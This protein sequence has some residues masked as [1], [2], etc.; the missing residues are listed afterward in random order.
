MAMGSFRKRLLLVASLV[1][2]LFVWPFYWALLEA[3]EGVAEDGIRQRLAA[4]VQVVL[5]SADRGDGHYYQPR[6]LP[7]ERFAQLE[8]LVL[9]QVYG[10]SGQLLWQTPKATALGLSY[11]PDYHPEEALFLRRGDYFLYDQDLVHGAAKVS[12]VTWKSSAE[13]DR[14]LRAF[15]RQLKLWLLSSLCALIALLWLGLHWGLQPLAVLR[16]QLTELQQGQRDT[17]DDRVP[18]E[19]R[20]LTQGL[21]QMLSAERQQRERYR[22]TLADL[23]H[24]LKTPLAVLDQVR[25]ALALRSD[26]QRELAV[27]DEQVQRMNQQISYQLQRA[28]SQRSPLDRSQHPLVPVLNKLQASLDKVYRDKQV[29]FMQQLPADFALSLSEGD[30]LEVFGNLLDNAYR[31]CVRQVRIQCV[32]Q[33]NSWQVWVEDDGAGVPQ[34]LRESIL[35]RGVR[36]DEQ[37][38]GQGI[39]LAVVVDILDSYGLG[40]SVGESSL[41]G[42]CF[43]LAPL[44]AASAVD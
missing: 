16:R 2:V 13:F 30:A 6:D 36:A 22:T 1:L 14:Q 25:H 23:A 37:H 43:R 38:P 28:V 20:A 8:T 34:A 35:R 15:K 7:N 19:V 41:G 17:L 44:E 11:T 32:Q 9:G 31:L 40:L 42:A 33:G 4:D 39:G 21:N 27:L 29:Q 18:D 24:S 10:R 3:Y 5:A 26:C 12:I